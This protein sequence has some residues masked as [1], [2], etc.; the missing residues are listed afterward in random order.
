MTL[1]PFNAV[2]D[3]FYNIL[4]STPAEDTV[5]KL[6]RNAAAHDHT[7]S[8][9]ALC[10]LLMIENARRSHAEMRCMELKSELEK[11]GAKQ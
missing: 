5:T 4:K 7:T 6:M 10:S 8:M 3:D 11:I 2:M 1:Q 9:L